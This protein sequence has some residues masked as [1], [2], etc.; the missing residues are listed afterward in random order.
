MFIY[1]EHNIGPGTWEE[2]FT[3]LPSIVSTV[4]SLQ[5]YSSLIMVSYNQMK[6]LLYCVLKKKKKK[7]QDFRK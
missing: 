5:K 2:G 6:P 3:K 1:K 4:C 7:R